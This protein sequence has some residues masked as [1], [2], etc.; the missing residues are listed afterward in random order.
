MLGRNWLGS[1]RINWCRI[2]Y[3]PSTG[4]QNLLEKYDVVFQDK[5]GS[6]QG[7]Q[8]KIEVDPEATPRFC[9]ARTLPY[10]MRAKVEEEIDRLVSDGILEPVEYADWAA[11]VVAVLKSDRKSIDYVGISV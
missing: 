11:P 8:A 3:T 7:Q 9:K 2:H 10:A 5:L 1:I 6:F 4:L